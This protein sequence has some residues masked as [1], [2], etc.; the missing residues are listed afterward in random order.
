MPPPRLDRDRAAERARRWLHGTAVPAGQATALRQLGLLLCDRIRGRAGGP[1]VDT[2][3]AGAVRLPSPATFVVLP[4]ADLLAL[5]RSLAKAD[6]AP[7]RMRAGRRRVWAPFFG[8]VALSYARLGDTA[9]VS[10]L[11]RTAARLGLSAADLDEAETWLLEQQRRD[12]AF[13]LI[14][15]ELAAVADE[16][17]RAAALLRLTVEVLW[18]LAESAARGESSAG[19]VAAPG[20][21][22]RDARRGSPAAGSGWRRTA[23]R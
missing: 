14:A 10:A 18:A 16:A 1:A 23:G 4:R 12:G 9:A 19:R 11:V 8:A 6:A 7:G 21:L 20:R 13:G 5:T 17:A 3:E 22:R 15:V 2:G